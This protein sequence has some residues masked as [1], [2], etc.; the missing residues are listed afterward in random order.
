MQHLP[1]A[2]SLEIDQ[3]QTTRISAN[4]RHVPLGPRDTNGRQGPQGRTGLDACDKF[5]RRSGFFFL[6]LIVFVFIVGVTAAGFGD[7]YAVQVDGAT[8][9]E[10]HDFLVG[11][12][13][14]AAGRIRGELTLF[15][16]D[17]GTCV[18]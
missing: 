15:E 10:A 4:K 11:A 14:A 18:F 12:C 7:D 16:G 3:T 8:R 9:S 1:N 13:S 5:Q 17:D 6:V 2:G